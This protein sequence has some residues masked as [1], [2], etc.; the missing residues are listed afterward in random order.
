MIV[1]KDGDGVGDAAD[2]L[3]T[4]LKRRGVRVKLDAH[5]D[6]SFGRRSTDHELRGVPVRLEVG[7]RDLAEGNVTVVRRDT[8]DKTPSPVAAAAKAVVDA[9]ARGADERCTTRAAQRLAART[10]E[11]ATL[12]EAVEAAQT[13]FAVIPGALA[14]E[15]GEN[16]LNAKSVSIRCLRRPDGTLPEA[17]DDTRDLVAVVARA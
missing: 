13:G 17:A 12:D 9:L 10:V 15:A 5:V 3:V 8:G 16:K 1:V 4:E 7:P 14:D 2:A 6:V 11:V